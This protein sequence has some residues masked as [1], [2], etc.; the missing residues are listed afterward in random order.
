MPASNLVRVAVANQLTTPPRIEYL[1][2][3]VGYVFRLVA[4][5]FTVTTDATVLQREVELYVFAKT[6]QVPGDVPAAEVYCGPQVAS[7]GVLY[8][9]RSGA[10]PDSMTVGATR[11]ATVGLGEVYAAGGDRIV[12]ECTL[13][14]AENALVD[15]YLELEAT[16]ARFADLAE[17]VR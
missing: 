5:K 8:E 15:L 10:V 4:A 3:D 13:G 1:V 7:E 6:G 9:V 17:L 12:A 14:V 2:P 16:D 11:L